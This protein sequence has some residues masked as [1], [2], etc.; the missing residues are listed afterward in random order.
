MTTYLLRVCFATPTSAD[1]RHPGGDRQGMSPG[2]AQERMKT[3]GKNQLTPP[4]E[5]PW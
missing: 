3:E 5:T 1:I 4:K 2:A